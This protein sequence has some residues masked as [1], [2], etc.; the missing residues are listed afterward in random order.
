VSGNATIGNIISS[1][2]GGNITGANVISANLF[3]GTLTTQ[4]QPNITSTGT[5]AT[6]SVTGNGTF[7]NVSATIF[8]GALTGAAS[9]A[10]TAGT[11]TTAAQPNITST[12]TLTSLS[13][14]GTS[15]LGA[16]GNVTITG[17]TSGQ[18]LSTNGS[19][20][21]SF[22]TVGTAIVSN[23]NSNV[24]VA[25]A[26][27][28]VTTS[29]NGNANILTVTGTGANIAGTLS[30][31]GNASFANLTSSGTGGD[32]TGANVIS[33]NT[34]SVS[35][36]ATIGN[37]VS[38]GSGGNITGANVISANILI[39]TVTTG[40]APLTVT[41]TTRVSN[42]NVAYANVADNINV[43]APGT[44]TAYILGANATTGNI[45]E[46]TSSGI[47]MNLANNAITATTF[48]GTVN[49]TATSAGT[50]TSAAHPNITSVGTLASLSVS[51]DVAVGNLIGSHANGN[52]NVN[53]ATANGNV[54]VTSAGNTTITVTGTGANISGTLSVSGNATIGGN[55][56]T[57]GAGGGNITGANVISANTFSATGNITAGNANLGNA[58]T[59]NF[60]TGNGSQ[61]NSLTFGNIATFSTAGLTTDE[62]YLP[63][64]TRLNVSNSGTSGYLFDQYGATVNPAIYV[65]SGQTLAFN[66]NVSGHPFLIQTSG[67]ANYSVGLEHVAT[68]GTVLTTTSAQGQ[69]AGTLYWK[70]P[71]GITG[72]YK[73]QCSIHGGMNGNIVVSDAN[74]ANITVGLATYATTANAVAGGNVSGQVGNSLVASTV[75]TN[76][77]PNITSI[78]S[79]TGLTVSNATGVVNFITTANVS[80]G[81]VGNLKITGGTVDY[82][83]RTDGAGN[84][85]WVAQSGGGVTGGASISNGTSNV[86]IATSGGNVTTSVNGN[87]NILVITGTGANVNGTLSVTGQSNLGAVGNVKISGGTSGYVLQT[88]G[89]SNLSWVAQS[90]GGGAGVTDVSVLAYAIALS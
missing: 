45:T 47:S 69:I 31:S 61:L 34:V 13:V 63:A 79:L 75:Y 22:I 9:S 48:I 64:I 37:I 83:L 90:G 3:T 59:A 29:V 57:S 40:T 11:V 58:V 17:G 42:L 56:I 86:N 88:D 78:G 73:Y 33:A 27:G 87:A 5:L 4:A 66:L 80:L 2:T 60:F 55:L 28:N 18:V 10:T 84:L 68:T 41:S 14:S 81:A 53:I 8:T 46:F 12:G 20:G 52:S 30:V 74:I 85:S 15:N 25:T 23:G 39:S 71:Y 26:G 43:S 54:T 38:S 1:G 16:V 62:L 19:G 24:S 21:L 49:G 35:G 7:G 65:T 32:I 67:S 51:G 77:Q 72:N 76:A 44:G 82:V 50:V 6:L 36:N 89:A 70:I